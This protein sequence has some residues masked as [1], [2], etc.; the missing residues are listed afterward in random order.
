MLDITEVESILKKVTFAPEFP[1]RHRAQFIWKYET[2]TFRGFQDV[3]GTYDD[4]SNEGFVMR[5]ASMWLP[6]LENEEEVIRC[7]YQLVKEL[8][9]HEAGECFLVDN[10]KI[11]DPHKKDS[12]A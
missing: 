10:K 7:A 9:L 11:F 4:P 8:M 3:K 1:Y 5:A 12:H 6:H 2:L